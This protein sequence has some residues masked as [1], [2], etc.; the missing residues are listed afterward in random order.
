[1]PECSYC[2]KTFPGV[3]LGGGDHNWLTCATARIAELETALREIIKGE[4][5]FSRDRLTHATNT[6]ESMQQIARDALNADQPA[7]TA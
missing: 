3:G 5:A 2:R 1:M 6:I 4:G 7:E